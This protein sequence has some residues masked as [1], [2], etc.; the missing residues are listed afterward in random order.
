MSQ[1][2]IWRG[3]ATDSLKI[4]IP[5]I[6]GG[7]NSTDGLVD[8]LIRL[9]SNLPQRPSDRQPYAGLFPPGD[10][11]SWRR[12]ASDRLATLVPKI[13]NIEANSHDDEIDDLIRL[14]S[15]LPQRPRDRQPYAGLFPAADLM[16]L[17][18]QA[19]D[20]LFT[21][22]SGLKGNASTNDGL[23]DDLV[24]AIS[25]LPA[26]PS[27]RKPYEGLFPGLT[28]ST[29]R[30]QAA[31][32]LKQLVSSLENDPNPQDV[33][34]DNLIRVLNK[35]PARPAD[36]KPYAGLYSVA[37]PKGLI[38]QSQL[39]A[40][41]PFSSKSRLTKL[42]P[43]INQTLTEF[44]INTPR[45]IA[46]F[47]AQTAH[48]SDAFNTNEEYASG[49]DYEGRA[50]LGN[51]QP[52]DGRRFKGRGL[53]QVTGRANYRD[54]GQALGV[55]LISNPTRLAD[56]DLAARSAGWFWN[57]EGL[58][59]FADRDDVLTITRRINGG[60]NGLDDRKAYLSRA[61]RVFNI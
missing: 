22:I 43:F 57:R 35:L 60:Y 26:R 54:C 3:Q 37:A 58:N 36:Q 33:L 46:H 24:R 34:V 19:G 53:I 52:G 6:M 42:L 59:Q 16:T 9:L 45:R 13:P 27:G 49:A 29:S 51:T 4:L 21:L 61:K 25:K 55:D 8:N 15:N 41:A 30:N 12:Q 14:L 38:T 18:K 2:D 32:R 44:K 50:D 28:I 10:V 47:I 31:E 23:V 48:E 40:I 11:A 17:R 39:E 56:F 5:K 7:I 20:R 1:I